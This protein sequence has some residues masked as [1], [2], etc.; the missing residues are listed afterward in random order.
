MDALSGRTI[1]IVGAGRMGTALSAAFRAAAL[2]VQGPLRRAEAPTG[3]VVILCVPD[4]EIAL[5]AAAVPKES[6]IGHTA[7]A[8]TLDVFRGRESFSMHPLMTAGDGHAEF[9]GASAAIAGSS[10]GALAVASAIVER[11]GCG[12]SSCAMTNESPITPPRRSPRTT[13]SPWSRWRQ[14]SRPRRA[15]S[16]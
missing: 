13:S 3:N 5:A 10:A 14:D 15:W 9:K 8:M 7:G 16:G 12:P 6:L 2:E 1:S 4:R 11:L